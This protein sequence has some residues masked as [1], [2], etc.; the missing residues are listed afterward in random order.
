MKTSKT[1]KPSKPLLPQHTARVKCLGCH[2]PMDIDMAPYQVSYGTWDT[3]VFVPCAEAPRICSAC[4]KVKK[5][6]EETRREMEQHFASCP[7]H[8]IGKGLL[9]DS[10]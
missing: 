7:S 5:I 6:L 4:R 10:K 1:S 2:K 3:R 8:L 9:H